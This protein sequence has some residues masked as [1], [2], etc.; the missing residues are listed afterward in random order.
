M[1]LRTDNFDNALDSGNSKLV[2]ELSKPGKIN[3]LIARN[4]PDL[5][6]QFFYIY[7][8]IPECEQIYTE[9]PERMKTRLSWD[10]GFSN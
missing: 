8:Y 9:S 3:L 7:I 6:V 10:H 4:L 5:C 1:S 2:M